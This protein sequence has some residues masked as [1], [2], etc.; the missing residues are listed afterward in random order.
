MSALAIQ[1][2]RINCSV[3]P[4]L[5]LRKPIL[6]I[7]IYIYI[8]VERERYVYVYSIFK[9]WYWSLLAKALGRGRDL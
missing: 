7:Y 6:Y 2:F 9:H 1:S 5:V 4:D 8:Y 3:A